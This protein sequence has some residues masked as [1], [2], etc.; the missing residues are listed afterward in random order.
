MFVLAAGLVFTVV[1]ALAETVNRSLLVPPTPTSETYLVPAMA[2]ARGHDWLENGELAVEDGGAGRTPA[3]WQMLEATEHHSVLE[4]HEAYLELSCAEGPCITG[5]VQRRPELPA[6]RY[7]LEAQVYLGGPYTGLAARLGFDPTGLQDIG[8]ESVRWSGS[9]DHFGWQRLALEVE[10]AGG[11]ASV[12][13]V[14]DVLAPEGEGRVAQL[15]LIGA[16]PVPTA[17]AIEG[18][19]DATPSPTAP[20]AEERVLLVG[21]DELEWRSA[22]E[23]SSVM[24]RAASAGFTT[25]Y[26]QVR[27][28]G[29]AYYD[30]AVEPAAPAIANGGRASW[31]PLSEAVALAHGAGLRLYAWL[32]VLPVWEGAEPPPP[33]TPGHMYDLLSTRYGDS[34]LQAPCNEGEAETYWAS[35]SHQAVRTYLASVAR[36]LTTRYGVDGVFLSGVRYCTAPAEAVAAGVGDATTPAAEAGAIDEGEWKRLQVTSLL[37]GIVNGAREGRPSVLVSVAVSPE[38]ES[39][40]TCKRCQDGS[41]WLAAGLAD[42]LVPRFDESEEYASEQVLQEAVVAWTSH[43]SGGVVMPAVSA[44][45]RSFVSVSRSVEAVRRAGAGGIVVSSFAAL[46]ARGYWDDLARDAFAT[47]AAVAAAGG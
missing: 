36:D 12:F 34:W 3:G 11:A 18:V 2:V 10:H 45:V 7:T 32:D 43:L 8:A 31:D 44:E 15:R 6:G 5:L 17:I 40:A 1:Y 13:V 26:L 22:A 30:S 23:L 42:A 38:D 39:G 46:D 4:R 28:L 33:L 37:Q 20:T 27:R 19:A 35:P 41:G 16:A 9:A 14:F 24:Q 21:A 25:V 29:Y 47:Q